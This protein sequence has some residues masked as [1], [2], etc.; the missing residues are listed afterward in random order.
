MPWTHFAR[1]MRQRRENSVSKQAKIALVAGLVIAVLA[2]LLYWGR[3]HRHM[4]SLAQEQA[5]E[6]LARS[7]VLAPPVTTPTDA[8]AKAAIFWASVSEPDKLEPVEIELPLSADSVQRAKQLLRALIASAPKPEQRTLPP[9][10]ILL[11]IYFLP[12]G[13]A[14]ADFSDSL[15]TKTPSGILS[16]EMAVNS[17]ARTLEAN[18]PELHRLKIL[19]HGQE[20]DTLAGHLDLTGFFDLHAPA[21]ETPGTPPQAGV[22]GQAAPS[23]A[24]SN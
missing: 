19:I 9:D 18:L 21:T 13:T 8:P 15:A 10:T 3:L 20:A 4:L 16:E 6:E 22:S 1:C 17:I 11:G 12:E 23:A 7:Q 24:P 14:I 5:S 2:G